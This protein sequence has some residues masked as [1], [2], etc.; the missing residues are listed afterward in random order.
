MKTK[1][2]LSAIIL[3][4][5]L[6]SC[7]SF[8]TR[9]ERDVY[10]ISERDTLSLTEQKNAPGVRNFGVVY[11]SSKVF[12]SNRSVIQR[13]SVVERDY[14]DFIR[15]GVF[16]SVG[17]IG[18][19]KDNKAGTGLF[20]VFPDFENLKNSYQGQSNKTFSGGIYRI[21]VGEWRLRWFRD[22]ANWTFGTSMLE[23]LMPEARI[24]K[25]LTS[26]FP[27]QLKK[28]YYIYES[29]PYIALSPQI[30]FGYYP[31]QYVN[32]SGALEIGSIGGLNIRAYLG[33]AAGYN[34]RASYQVR[35]S[36]NPNKSTTSS[37]P[38]AGI[39]VSVLDFHNLVPETL[40]EWKDYRHSSWDI[41]LLQASILASGA[42]SSA[43][44]DA[45][46]TALSGALIKIANAAIALPFLNNQF[47]V[48]TSLANLVI[49]GRGEWGMG[50]L[51]IRF[52]YWQTI[53][54]D[55]LS[56]EPFIEFNYYPS[57]FFHIGNRINLKISNMLNIGLVMGYASGETVNGIGKDLLDEFGYNT[58][59]GRAYIGFSLGVADRIFIP[60]E[61]WYNK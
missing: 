11:P 23:I 38:Y 44:S 45:S 18:S 59:F 14:P 60:E 28:R 26:I 29:F 47:Y 19:S 3:S 56:T 6:I 12:M 46:S 51:P 52:G 27:V 4:M 30:S 33:Y 34:S 37:F 42:D 16:E 20:G 54:A 55:E 24:E 22:A 17:L 21:G 49:L 43:L 32:I 50:I 41:G 40:K 1:I 8:S 13:D 9:T 39:G 31:S 57:S 48:G 7:G 58:K 61:I 25:T 15:L 2:L 5:L 35:M 10:T 53:L 36:T